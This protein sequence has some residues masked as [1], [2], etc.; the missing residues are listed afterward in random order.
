MI[1][2]FDAQRIGKKIADARKECNMTQMELADELGVSYQAVSNW[3]RSKSLPDIDKYNQISQV[4]DLSL[5]DLLGSHEGARTIQIVQNDE[6]MPVED[7]VQ[8]APLMKPA[9]VEQKVTDKHLSFEQIVEI[10][11]FISDE[12]LEQQV[13]EHLGEPD[14]NQQLHKL[15]PFLSSAYIKRY[16]DSQLQAGTKDSLQLISK[17]VFALDDDDVDAIFDQVVKLFGPN[18][19]SLKHFYHF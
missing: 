9:Q 1:Q 7:L 8:A 12:T 6:P 5:E 13:D 4:L 14:F 18:E 11:P 16:I 15:A 3:E 19:H 17:L 10:A 2:I